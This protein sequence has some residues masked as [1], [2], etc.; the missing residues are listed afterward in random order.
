MTAMGLSKS[1]RDQ[2]HRQMQQTRPAPM[3]LNIVR[4]AF[5]FPYTSGSAAVGGKLSL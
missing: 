4:S 1:F 2:V 3:D 5:L